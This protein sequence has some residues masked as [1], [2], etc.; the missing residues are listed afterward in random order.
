MTTVVLDAL[1]DWVTDHHARG[2]RYS[3][4]AVQAAGEAAVAA[5]LSGLSPDR[6]LEAGRD[7]YFDE[8][9]RMSQPSEIT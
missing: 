6:C 1:L 3:A 7:A 8:I 2:G 5:E 4:E 9:L